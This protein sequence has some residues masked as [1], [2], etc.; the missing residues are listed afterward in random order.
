MGARSPSIKLRSLIHIAHHHTWRKPPA[1]TL[2][3]ETRT[4]K[5]YYKQ[6]LLANADQ[7]ES[8]TC[9]F[10]G[11][12]MCLPPSLSYEGEFIVTPL[13]CAHILS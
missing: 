5:N 7:V 10:S 2:V 9:S 1:I 12:L 11:A 3:V 6:T 13:H 4:C 8:G